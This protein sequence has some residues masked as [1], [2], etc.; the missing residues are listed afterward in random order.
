MKR[1]TIVWDYCYFG[2]DGKI[3]DQEY[4]LFIVGDTN[5]LEDARKMVDEFDLDGELIHYSQGQGLGTCMVEVRLIDKMYC[6]E[7]YERHLES[8]KSK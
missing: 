6:E 8:N 3:V 2:I 5:D 7:D 4:P 1:F